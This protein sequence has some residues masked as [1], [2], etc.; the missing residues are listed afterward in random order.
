MSI[1]FQMGGSILVLNERIEM[2]CFAK[3]EVNILHFNVDSQPFM[4]RV[5]GWE[6]TIC[7]IVVS[8]LLNCE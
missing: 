8:C 7:K 4:W 1:H 5:G 2:N 3:T 6:G